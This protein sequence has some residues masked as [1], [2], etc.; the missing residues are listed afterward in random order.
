MRKAFIR[1]LQHLARKDERIL[2]LTG[3]LGFMALEPFAEEFPDRFYNVGVAEQNMIGLASGLAKEGFIPYVYSIAPFCILRPL[4]F[5]RNGPIYHQ[6][7][8]RIV[9][10]GAG[11]DYGNNGITHYGID[12]IGSLRCQPGIQLISPCDHRQAEATFEQTWNDVGPIYYRLNKDDITTVPGLNG[13]FSACRANVLK[14]SGEITLLALG[15]LASDALIVAENLERQGL[16]CKV[17]AVA[18]VSPPPTEHLAEIIRN[19]SLVFTL[20]NHY[21]NGALGSL[22]AEIIAEKGLNCRLI[23]CGVDALLD[24]RTGSTK[25]LHKRF[26]IDPESVTNRILREWKGSF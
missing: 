19:S 8:V 24:G 1:T 11:F 6:L 15:N 16:L 21:I 18:C 13:K 7:K 12:D 4:E 23:R 25:T 17:A 3:D 14:P 26:G 22:T 20:E 2:L 9:G 5:I 10:V